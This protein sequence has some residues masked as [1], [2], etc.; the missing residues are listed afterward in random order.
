MLPLKLV[1]CGLMFDSLQTKHIFN[2]CRT[3]AACV[4]G[5]ICMKDNCGY[6]VDEHVWKLAASPEDYRRFQQMLTRSFIDLNPETRWC[7]NPKSCGRAI[8]YVVFNN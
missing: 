7:P 2:V 6:K 8:K 1:C 3:G 4:W 5:T